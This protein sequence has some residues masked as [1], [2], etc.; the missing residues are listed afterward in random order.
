MR[1][2]FQK[3]SIKVCIKDDGRGF[4]VEKAINSKDRPIGLGL[5]G[6][7]ERV[8]LVNGTFGIESSPGGN[9]TKINIEIPI[10]QEVGN[11]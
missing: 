11:G 9:G 1:L 4:N 10:S 5:L 7:K 6:M 2:Y 8:G 3:S